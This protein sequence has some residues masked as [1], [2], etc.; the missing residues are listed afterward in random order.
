MYV[1]QEIKDLVSNVCIGPVYLHLWLR[2]AAGSRPVATGGLRRFGP[3]L[4]QD[5]E[6]R[7][8]RQRSCGRLRWRAWSWRPAGLRCG[9]IG[10]MVLMR[11]RRRPC[12]RRRTVIREGLRNWA[13]IILQIE[14]EWKLYEEDMTVSPIVRSFIAVFVNG[15]LIIADL[16]NWIV[17]KEKRRNQNQKAQTDFREYYGRRENLR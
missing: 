5:P 3:K 13:V 10:R 7:P 9:F 14:E 17:P 11:H 6:R 15:E 2:R 12:S 4:R 1:H 8:R 16:N